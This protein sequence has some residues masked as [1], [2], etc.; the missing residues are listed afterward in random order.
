AFCRRLR[1]D[2]ERAHQAACFFYVTQDEKGL[3]AVKNLLNSFLC[4]LHLI[5][6]IELVNIQELDNILQGTEIVE[7]IMVEMI[8]F[9]VINGTSIGFLIQELSY[10]D[11]IQVTIDPRPYSQTDTLEKKFEQTFQKLLQSTRYR[12][13]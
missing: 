5:Q 6:S 1:L 7:K 2:P 12:S 4:H 10:I 13:R 3:K 9:Q 8:F 11:P